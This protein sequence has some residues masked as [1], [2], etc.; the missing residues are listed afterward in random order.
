MKKFKKWLIHKLGGMCYDDF[1][2]PT[3]IHQNKRTEK[4][5]ADIL[6]DENQPLPPQDYVNR[7]L[8]DKMVKGLEPYIVFTEVENER[9]Y[10]KIKRFRAEIEV[11]VE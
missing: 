11:V 7:M 10:G 6:F 2:Q 4:L 3:I 8:M 1:I 9:S 5:T